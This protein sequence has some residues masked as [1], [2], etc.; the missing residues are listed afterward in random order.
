M[1]PQVRQQAGCKD[2]SALFTTNSSEP[3]NHIIKV[4]IEW[5]ESQLPQLIEKLKSIS[6]GQVSKVESAVVERGEW[7]FTS[8]YAD[9][10][11]PEKCWFSQMSDSAKKQ[12]MSEV[13][14]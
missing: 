8:Q 13:S 10:I 2:P 14:N 7:H 11:I 12:H 3:L 1:L 4:E 5:N 6:D 9:M